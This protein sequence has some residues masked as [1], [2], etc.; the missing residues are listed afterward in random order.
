MASLGFSAKH[1]LGRDELTSE[2]SQSSAKRKNDKKYEEAEILKA[3]I[4]KDPSHALDNEIFLNKYLQAFQNKKGIEEK[5]TRMDDI[6]VRK[7]NVDDLVRLT[8]KYYKRSSHVGNKSERDKLTK[9]QLREIKERSTK[10]G[11]REI[12]ELQ[13]IGKG[14]LLTH[15][16]YISK[17][18]K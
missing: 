1:G 7:S 5:V 6:I 9:S 8:T 13:A 14:Q 3:K 18:K 2:E 11:N 12:R 4:K 16:E 17:K 15:P 10:A